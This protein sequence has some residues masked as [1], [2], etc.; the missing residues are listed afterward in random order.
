[1]FIAEA[2]MTLKLI[3]DLLSLAPTLKSDVDN[4]INELKSDD[5]GNKKLKNILQELEGLA[6]AIR[7][8]L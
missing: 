2:L 6:E 1:M 7:S 4:I 5:D 8:K 3:L